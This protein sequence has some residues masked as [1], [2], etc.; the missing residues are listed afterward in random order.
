M[1]TAVLGVAITAVAL[2]T[3]SLF[4][5]IVIHLGNNALAIWFG[6]SGVPVDNLD[7]S[8]LVGAFLVSLALMWIIYRN[9]TLY[10][11]E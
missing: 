8:L 7:T 6:E 2:M 3:G 4:P 11:N 5:G 1:T 10:P 9:R